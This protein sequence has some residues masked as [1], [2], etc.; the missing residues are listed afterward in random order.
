MTDTASQSRW[1]VIYCPRHTLLPSRRWAHIEEC[2]RA[3]GV[4][5]DFVQSEAAGSVERLAKMM[6][7]NGYK[8]IV[9]VGGDSALNDVANVLMHVERRERDQIA[10]GVI[11]NGVMND[12]ARF[13]GFAE[14]NVPHAVRSIKARRV[15]RIDLGRLAYTNQKGEAC[16]RYFLNCVNI[17]LIA[18]ITSLRSRTRHA[19]QSRT[20]SLLVSFVMMLFQR[21][22]YKMRLRINTTTVDRRVMTVCVGNAHGYGQTPSAVPYNGLLDVSVVYHPAISQLVEGFA[23]FLRGQFLNSRS[24]HPYRTAAVEVADAG[25]ALICVDGRMLRTPVGAYNIKVVQEELN[26]IMGE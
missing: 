8:T 20:L 4:E 22:E 3:E 10:V 11:P 6:V 25:G 26:F 7:N 12:F 24:M 9:V 16:H 21:M 14:N 19:L 18:A 15:R 13:W 2:L 17:G 1:G 23:F 5:F